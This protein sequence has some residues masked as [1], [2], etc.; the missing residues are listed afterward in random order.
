MWIGKIQEARAE[1]E[2][3]VFL[4][5]FWFYWPEELPVGIQHYHGQQE[6]VLSNHADIVDAT[7]I[8]GPAEI[9]HWNESDEQD[10]ISL[11]ALFWR[12]TYD[13]SKMGPH[14]K[15]GLSVLRKHCVCRREYN[16]DRTMF[17]CSNDECNIWNH[18]ECLE[19]DLVAEFNLMLQKNSLQKTLDRRAEQF[20]KAQQ[21]Q[22]R[23]LGETISI[24][25]EAATSLIKNIMH[26]N[27]TGK[28]QEES[29]GPGPLSPL[30]P[31]SPRKRGRPPKAGKKAVEDR[32]LVKVQALKGKAHRSGVVVAI[33][34]LLPGKGSSAEIKEWTVPAYCMKCNEPL[35]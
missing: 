11:K 19:K 7:T 30:S 14:G 25:K 31:P 13:I 34:R 8:S 15:G 9:S 23:S 32:I 20:A 18:R 35:D 27:E 33:V 22:E 21:E 29:E 5:V 2:N 10:D 4:R 12:Q 17:K 28:T 24:G 3:K 1:N 16:P 26:W 6:V